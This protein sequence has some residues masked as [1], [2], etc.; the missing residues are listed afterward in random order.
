MKFNYMFRS[1]NNG[2]FSRYQTLVSNTILTQ[3]KVTEWLE[4]IPGVAR[5]GADINTLCEILEEKKISWG[6]F[7]CPCC[8]KSVTHLLEKEVEPFI[9]A[10]EAIGFT[11]VRLQ[12]ISGNY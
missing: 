12:G 6:I 8:H 2:H 3:E 9:K 5:M 11:W 7:P 10:T 1:Q 4:A